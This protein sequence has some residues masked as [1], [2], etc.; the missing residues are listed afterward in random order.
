[1][2]DASPPKFQ[3]YACGFLFSPD[4]GR[5]LLIRIHRFITKPYFLLRRRTIK[6]L[7]KSGHIAASGSN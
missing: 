6:R 2:A 7:E 5:G 4:R 1:M 3:H